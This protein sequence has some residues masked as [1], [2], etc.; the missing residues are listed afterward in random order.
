MPALAAASAEPAATRPLPHHVRPA[1]RKGALFRPDWDMTGLPCR[2]AEQVVQAWESVY[3]VQ[4]SLEGYPSQYC[5][6]FLVVVEQAGRRQLYLLFNLKQSRHLLV[7][8][9]GQAPADAAAL[10]KLIGEGKKYLKKS[11]FE[12][13]ELAAAEV[14]DTLG[15]YFARA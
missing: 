2:S 1:P 7:C 6:A 8:V 10:L 12:L 5:A 14:P 13:E 9:P 15:G 3:N 4:L 11:G